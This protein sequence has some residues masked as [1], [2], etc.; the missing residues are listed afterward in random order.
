MLAALGNKDGLVAE[1]DKKR[2]KSNINWWK[3]TPETSSKPAVQTNTTKPT[4]KTNTSPSP[5]SGGWY[6]FIFT[7]QELTSELQ[8]FKK[9]HAKAKT[10]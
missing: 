6:N 2:F 4:A 8:N 3:Y 7:D 10:G 5:S 1:D 9:E